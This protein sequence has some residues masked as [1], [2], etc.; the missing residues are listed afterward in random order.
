MRRP[1]FG[2][3]DLRKGD[4]WN[5]KMES[6]GCVYADFGR[7]GSRYTTGVEDNEKEVTGRRSK[8]QFSE[9]IY[10]DFNETYRSIEAVVKRGVHP[11]VRVWLEG[12]W[13]FRKDKLFTE[14]GSDIRLE[15]GLSISGAPLG[16]KD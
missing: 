1:Q 14:V 13:H 4:A 11:G 2:A 5:V 16:I 3:N 7:S 8:F 12:N 9:N 6:I 15:S 10:L